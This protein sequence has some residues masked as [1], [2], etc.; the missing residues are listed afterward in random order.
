MSQEIWAMK[1]RKCLLSVLAVGMGAC[2]LSNFISIWIFGKYYIYEP[3]RMIL[4]IETLMMI[5]IISFSLFS[6]FSDFKYR[7]RDGFDE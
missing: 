5:I 1:L 3:N 4:S 2:L 7:S 6:F